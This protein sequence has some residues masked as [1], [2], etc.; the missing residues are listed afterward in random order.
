[1]GVVIALVLVSGSLI[2]GRVT[3]SAEIVP[4]TRSAE[5]GFARDM[6]AHHQQ[7]VSMSMTNRDL[8]DDPEIRLFAYDIA[9]SQAQQAGQMFGWLS[10][11]G[12]PQASGEPAMTWMHRPVPGQSGHE[13]HTAAGSGTQT[14]EPGEMPGKATHEQLRELGEL[15][16]Q[17]AERQFLELMIA[18]HNGGIEMANALL[19]RTDNPTVTALAT[20]IVQ[21]QQ[22]EI[23]LMQDLLAA[24]TTNAD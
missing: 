5:A 20:S 10:A 24:R 7:A 1:M 13:A 23:K 12:L 4:D 21:A 18:H 6:Q 17:A 14:G 15:S 16:G 9:T 22:S 2:I 11:W 8:T 19:E 3:A